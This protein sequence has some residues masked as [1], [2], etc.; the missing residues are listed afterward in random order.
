MLYMPFTHIIIIMYDISF[1]IIYGVK[2]ARRSR[3][4]KRCRW[5][6][7]YIYL[8]SSMVYVYDYLYG[9]KT[10]RRSRLDKRCSWCLFV[11]LPV[12]YNYY[13]YPIVDYCCY[14]WCKFMIIYGTKIVRRSRQDTVTCK[15]L[16]SLINYNNETRQEL[17]LVPTITHNYYYLKYKL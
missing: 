5:S 9:V 13:I 17:Q 7:L 11:I 3:Q 10:T 14:L 6:L 12:M 1:M 4:D 16:L 15:L 8:S 2:T